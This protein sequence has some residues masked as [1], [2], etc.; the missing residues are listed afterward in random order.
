M[1]Y[2]TRQSILDSIHTQ[3]FNLVNNPPRTGNSTHGK[4]VDTSQIT[5]KL[6][7]CRPFWDAYL[8]VSRVE[9]P[10][11]YVLRDMT[12]K[13]REQYLHCKWWFTMLDSV[14]NVSQSEGSQA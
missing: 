6:N 13:E 11:S 5:N 10:S 1:D 7:E 12:D 8:A 4:R 3:L 14:L 9:E 2:N